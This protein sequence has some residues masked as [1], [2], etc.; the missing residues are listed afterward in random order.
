METNGLASRTRA[1]EALEGV[2]D[3]ARSHCVRYL[4][5]QPAEAGE[6]IDRALQHAGFR[7]GAHSVAPD[8]TIRLDLSLSD[9]AILARMRPLRRRKIRRSFREA[10]K[11]EQT[12]DIEVFHRLHAAT[13]ERQ[14]FAP[15]T[16]KTLSTQWSVLGGRGYSALLFARLQGEVVAGVWLNHF[17]D[18]VTYR[19]PGWDA[20]AAGSAP[21]NDRLHWEAVQWARSIQAKTYDF[22][23]FDR[24][25]AEQLLKDQ[26]PPGEFESSP[27]AFKYSFGGQL[28]LLPVAQHLV[29]NRVGR[30]IFARLGEPVLRSPHVGRVAQKFRNG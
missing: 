23:G 1:R 2:L 15:L 8:A 9:E 20:A 21:V 28:L 4:V 11:I 10:I 24:G 12:D 29:P 27:Y 30:M 7:T 14:G 6:D 5:V 16:L 3:L 13:A 18:T 19:L 22:G 26:R 17:A 25:F